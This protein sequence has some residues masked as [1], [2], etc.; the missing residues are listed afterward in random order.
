MFELLISEPLVCSYPVFVLLM[1]AW[2]IWTRP[3]QSFDSS[4]ARPVVSPRWS[5]CYQIR[6]GVLVPHRFGLRSSA[7]APFFPIFDRLHSA[8]LVEYSTIF[9]SM[10]SRIQLRRED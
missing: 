8:T 7:I 2:A 9:A 4:S 5:S 3:S 1:L 10:N 6:G